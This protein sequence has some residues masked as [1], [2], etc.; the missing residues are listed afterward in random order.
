M[1]TSIPFKENIVYSLIEV[2][3]QMIAM[4][5]TRTVSVNSSLTLQCGATGM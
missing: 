2:K 4:D 3:V 5:T 1:I